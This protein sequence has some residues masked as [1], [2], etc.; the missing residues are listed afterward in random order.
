M[1]KLESQLDHVRLAA[2]CSASH[3]L[4]SRVGRVN[5]KEAVRMRVLNS[6]GD[7]KEEVK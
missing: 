2:D 1:L 4:G 6:R 3:R 7:L 5:N